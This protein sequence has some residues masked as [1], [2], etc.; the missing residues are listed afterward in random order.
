MPQ[1]KTK[2]RSHIPTRRRSNA[3]IPTLLANCVGAAHRR[4]RYS[5]KLRDVVAPYPI[6]C[7]LDEFANIVI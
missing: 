3:L 7:G 2:R 5:S 1:N 4:Y 6:N